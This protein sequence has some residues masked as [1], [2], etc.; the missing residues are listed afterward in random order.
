MN[1]RLDCTTASPELI[2]AFQCLVREDIAFLRDSY[3][4]FQE[5]LNSIVLPGI[6]AGERTV[7]VEQRQGRPAGLLILKHTK[8]E[9]KLCT[10]R[11]RPG[12]E[13][14]GLG[15]RMFEAAFD[16]LET[17]QPLL[18]VSEVAL[19]KFSRIFQH[20]G[21]DCSGT[22]RGLYLPKVSE[23]S[24]NGILAFDP[25]SGGS[26]GITMRSLRPEL[27]HG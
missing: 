14:K 24:Y 9:R 17:S 10:L 2:E 20:F 25:A 27:I 22:Y 26:L 12:F 3:P 19:P 15:I 21:F 1:F 7:I 23:L 4:N 6:A 16:I 8:E 11:V 13:Y 5:W 18:S